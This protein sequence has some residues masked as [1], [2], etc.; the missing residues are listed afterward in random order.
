[1]SRFVLD[2]SVALSWCF[3]DQKTAYTEAVFDALAHGD[4][5]LVPAIW[6][7]EMLNGLVVAERRKS[8]T[9]TQ[10]QAFIT[11]LSDLPVEV[12]VE[13]VGRVY[14]CVARLAR[15]HDLSSYDA[16]YLDLALTEGL[17]LATQDRSLRNAARKCDIGTF[18]LRKGLEKT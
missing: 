14:S 18:S 16:A 2:A 8:I 13:D 3:E 9:D 12:D 7:L 15:Q 11:D 5:A 10:F 1:M 17:P 4:A 6:P